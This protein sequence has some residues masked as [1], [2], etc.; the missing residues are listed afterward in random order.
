MNFGQ[1]Q[2]L[3]CSAC[4]YDAKGD[5]MNWKRHTECAK[6]VLLTQ[7]TVV[8]R[9]IRKDVS[10]ESINAPNCFVLPCANKESP[11]DSIY[12]GGA[13]G[14]GKS[15]WIST[16]VGNYIT[17]YPRNKIFLV[18]SKEHDK[19]LDEK[20]AGKIERIP[21]SHIDENELTLPSDCL[22]I[23]DDVDAYEKEQ[24]KNVFALYNKQLK[25]ERSR[26]ISCILSNHNITDYTATRDSLNNSSLFVIFPK[27]GSRYSLDRMLKCYVGLTPQQIK[28]IYKVDSRWVCVRKH[29]PCAVIHEKGAFLI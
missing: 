17:K 20:Y 25:N 23:F 7:G 29:T 18:S 6:H 24:K 28:R 26:N 2:N 12:I 13:P 14:C 11:R 16:Y 8:E 1:P 19:L 3:Y 5:H 10:G 4:N 22:I 15:F 21:V 9:R 27:S